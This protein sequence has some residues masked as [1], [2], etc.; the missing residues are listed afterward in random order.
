M[1][2]LHE[3]CRALQSGDASAAIVAGTNLILSPTTHAF[4]TAEGVLSP[5]GSCKTFDASADGY[6]RAEGISA[7]YVK[8]LEDAIRDG[9]PVRAVIR[10]SGVN[11]DGKTK[12]IL[13]PSSS[14]QEM[15]IR[16]VYAD[17]GLDPSDTAYVEVRDPPHRWQTSC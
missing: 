3:A 11:D 4:L 1:V 12:G 5:E 8:R 14:A 7:V 6:A 9:N 13:V 16:K 2:A 15:L 10:G 17:S